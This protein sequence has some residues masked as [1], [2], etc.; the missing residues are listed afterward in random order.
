MKES[1]LHSTCQDTVVNVKKIIY[2]KLY[3]LSLQK[4]SYIL[5]KQFMFRGYETQDLSLWLGIEYL[6]ED[7]DEEENVED[8]GKF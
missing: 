7:Y 2:A 1:K 6:L 3:S 5:I 4:L 8:D